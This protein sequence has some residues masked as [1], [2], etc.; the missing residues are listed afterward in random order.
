M[1]I[2]SKNDIWHDSKP[3][4]QP[5]FN[6][7]YGYS[8]DTKHNGINSNVPCIIWNCNLVNCSRNHRIKDCS[9]ILNMEGSCFTH[10]TSNPVNNNHSNCNNYNNPGNNWNNYLLNKSN[11]TSIEDIEFVREHCEWWCSFWCENGK[12]KK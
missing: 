2:H 9:Q 7:L 3:Y 4:I 5:D 10:N 12:Y 8:R 6:A 11:V 1:M